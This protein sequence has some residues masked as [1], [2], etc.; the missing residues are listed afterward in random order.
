MKINQSMCFFCN[1]WSWKHLQLEIQLLEIYNL[2]GFGYKLEAQ[3]I[4]QTYL[5]YSGPGC[6]SSQF[7]YSKSGR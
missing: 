4:V 6:A 7:M 2:E 1:V 5:D 3:D